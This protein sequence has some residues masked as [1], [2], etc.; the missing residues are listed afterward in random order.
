MHENFKLG[1]NT[2]VNLGDTPRELWDRIKISAGNNCVIDI[3]GITVCSS[4]FFM[5]M[6]HNTTLRMGRDHRMQGLVGIEM[7]EASTVEIG[8]YCL[9]SD[10]RV[11]TSD[12]H[13]VIDLNSGK[14]TNFARDISIGSRV[15]L[16]WQ[17]LILKG[18]KIGDGSV[19]SARSVVTRSSGSAPNSLLSGNPAR[20]IKTGVSWDIDRLPEL[21]NQP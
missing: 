18:S 20:T 14:R 21:A 2:T 13:S 9:W 11:W 12:M 17:S 16:G 15:W 10:C 4:T 6:A 1:E 19:V 8:D 5:T 7:L 3:K